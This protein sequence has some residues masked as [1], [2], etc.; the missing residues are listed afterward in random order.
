MARILIEDLDLVQIA[1]TK[2]KT[3]FGEILH[4]TS[5]ND[6]VY[7]VNRQGKPVSVVISYNKYIELTRNDQ[8]L[9]E[10]EDQNLTETEENK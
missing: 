4:E 9:K 5:V 8:K 6:K 2:A 3:R 7:V 10:M 1:A